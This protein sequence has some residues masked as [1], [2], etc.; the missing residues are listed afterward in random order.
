M[1][2]IIKAKPKEIADLVVAVQDRQESASEEML[3]RLRERK[4]WLEQN[5]Y[6]RDFSGPPPER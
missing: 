4:E 1:K 6:L 5:H 3:A 2:I